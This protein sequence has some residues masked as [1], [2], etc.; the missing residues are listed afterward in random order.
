MR[1][2][3][4]GLGASVVCM[5]ITILE[6]NQFLVKIILISGKDC[7]GFR[8]TCHVACGTERREDLKTWRTY[9]RARAA[10]RKLSNPERP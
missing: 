3:G 8:N 6:C 2:V 4:Q 5:S 7:L 9:F 1:T 10:A